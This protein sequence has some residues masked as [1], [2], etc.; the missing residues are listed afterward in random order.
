MRCA[1]TKPDTAPKRWIRLLLPCLLF[2][3]SVEIT[4]CGS[5]ATNTANQP[6]SDPE[7]APPPPQTESA[8]A[9]AQQQPP[10]AAPPASADAMAPA[11]LDELLAPVAL[12]P[13]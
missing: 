12:Y 5:K 9:Q 10:Q 6:Q 1:N 7:P 3:A 8:T 11:A 4:A 2:V 13:D